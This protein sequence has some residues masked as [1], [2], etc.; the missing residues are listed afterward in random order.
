MVTP[1]SQFV[2]S[3]SA[4]HVIVGER[5]KAV[6]DQTIL[7]AL[8]FWGGD[9]AI[10]AMD[11]NVRDRILDRPRA[12]EIMADPP[13]EPTYEELQERYG[14]PGV[15]EEELLLRMECSPEE[16]AM[17]RVAGPPP[18]YDR[19]DAGSPLVTLVEQLTRRTDRDYIHIHKAGLSL[20]LARTV[21]A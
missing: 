9:E 8:G 16:L 10:E 18:S 19:L 15:S 13:R 2:G 6:T 21:G 7:Y 1:L 12:R 17:L 5:Y 11:P 4:I 20:T 14:G 3:Q